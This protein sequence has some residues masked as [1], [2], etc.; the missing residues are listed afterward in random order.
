MITTP[1]SEHDLHAY[2]DH[3]LSAAERH[4]VAA[5]ALVGYKQDVLGN[6]NTCKPTQLLVRV[7]VIVPRTPRELDRPPD[8]ILNRVHVSLERKLYEHPNP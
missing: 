1:P 6:L 5:S 7:L 8:A 2:I 3:A 4:A